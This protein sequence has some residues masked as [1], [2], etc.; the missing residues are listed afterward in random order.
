MPSYDPVVPPPPI[1]S[2]P[3]P[4][5]ATSGVPPPPQ[6][7]YEAYNQQPQQQ[8]SGVP[9]PP[10][11]QYE[12][13]NQQ[14]QQQQ[15]GIPPPPQMQYEVNQQQPQQQ[16]GIPPPPQM[17]YEVNQQH[18]QQ[19]GIPSPPQMQYE[20]NQQQGGI[21]PPPQMQYEQQGQ[22]GQP[23]QPPPGMPPN[24]PNGYPE[25]PPSAGIY[26]PPGPR[27]RTPLSNP[28][29]TPPR[30]LY[31]MSPYRSL[32]KDLPATAQRLE[33]HYAMGPGAQP[34]YTVPQP[35][36]PQR[37]GGGGGISALLGGSKKKGGKGLFR[38]SSTASQRDMPQPLL[39]TMA[40]EFFG[41]P[42]RSNSQN[43]YLAPPSSGSSQHGA[44]L[45]GASMPI[46]HPAESDPNR[47]PPVRFDH[48]SPLSGFMNH[49]PHRVLYQNHTY[50]SAL[51][52]LEALKFIGH[53]P[54]LAERIRAVRDVQD[55]YPLSASMQEFVRADWGQVLK[56]Y[57][58]RFL[59]LTLAP[60]PLGA[61]SAT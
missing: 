25:G 15:G 52:L 28:L 33:R 53:R 59:L 6:M 56:L 50:P 43:S 49:S 41:G 32:L 47:P 22:Q 21:P 51:H 10:Q 45:L 17:Q 48:T 29:P 31:E 60:V 18:Q 14:Q 58:S 19:G 36:Q 5:Q 9:P 13:F 61:C 38:S 54:E 46:S 37:H 2:M 55:V 12:A 11:M 3:Q 20:V 30:D 40:G 57:L 44:G 8:Q 27:P 42:Q 34:Q 16:G 24:N 23:P 26:G 7:Q 35:Q 1:V 4:P 39:G